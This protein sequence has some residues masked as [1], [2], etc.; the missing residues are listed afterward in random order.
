[1]E[2][3]T[4]FLA[5]QL[6]EAAKLLDVL[7]ED[8]FRAKAYQ[9]AARQLESFEGDIND[10]FARGRL[11]EIRGVGQGLA[12]ELYALETNERL[13][14]LDELYAKVPEGVRSLFAVSGLGAKKIGLLW[15]NGI[16]S[17]DALAEAAEDGRIAALKG[18]GKKSAQNILEGAQFALEARKRMRYD[19]AE[20][21]ETRLTMLFTELL[22]E[23]DIQVAGEFRRALETTNGLEFVATNTNAEEIAN[24]LREVTE[25][26]TIEDSQV[27]ARLGERDVSV[28]VTDAAAFGSA[29]AVHTGSEDFVQG[30]RE[31]AQEGG[32]ELR[33]TGLFKDDKQLETPEETD[34]FKQLSLPFVVPERRER[35][36]PNPVPNLITLDDVRGLIHNHSTWS[37]AVF[38]IREMVAGA[39]ARGYAYL[40]MGDH[41]RTSY[42]A[43]GLSIERVVAQVEEIAEI[44]AELAE[45]G[46]DFEL[47]HGLEVDILPDGSLDYPDEVMATLDYA[48]VSV[49]QNFTLSEKAQTER[50]VRAV[51]NPYAKILGHLTGRLVL[52]RPGYAVDQ[53]AVIEAC[54][55]TGTVIEI[56]AN[57]HRLDMDWRWVIK[58]K[59]RGCKFSINPDAHHTDGF[60]DVYYGVLMARKAGLAKDDVVN[61]TATGGGFLELLK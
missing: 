19:V 12:Q 57:P 38:S 2:L 29:L 24:V 27:T 15:R 31:K 53:D 3:S 39:R 28:F 41:S 4:K 35:A 6:K 17:L 34:L 11:N 36:N 20:A 44:R 43:N 61:T 1:M 30:L 60:D 47:L 59:E 48:V 45:E 54:A 7:N 21:L 49:H 18:F 26:V 51:H 5:S 25:E 33:E 46:S 13:P 55:E 9:N 42:Y 8:P 22:P 56:N 52:R 32:L 50:I 37:D 40:G 16:D 58:A 23:A 14:I 10:L